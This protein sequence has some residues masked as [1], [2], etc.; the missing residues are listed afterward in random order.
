MVNDREIAIEYLKN[1]IVNKERLR[2]KLIEKYASLIYDNIK[3]RRSWGMQI[4]LLSSA[5]IGFA[6]PNLDKLSFIKTA[7]LWWV[8]VFFLTLTMVW[9]FLELKA[10]LQ[11]E[12]EELKAAIENTANGIT[13]STT[14]DE[15][16]LRKLSQGKGI[17][18]KDYENWSKIQRE[19][20]GDFQLEE[21]RFKYDALNLLLIFFVSALVAIILST[22]DFASLPDKLFFY[23]G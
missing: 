19:I 20:A 10:V 4:S 8:G 15:K 11:R 2:E 13:R 7:S 16:I 1:R 18:D 3:Q 5:I 9:G 6:L 21:T 12:L 23:R 22:I 14:E 17:S